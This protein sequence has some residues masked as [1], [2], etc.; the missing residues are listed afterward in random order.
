M[1]GKSKDDI[2]QLPAT[3][4]QRV[5]PAEVK[6]GQPASSDQISTIHRG[7]TVVGKIVGEGTVHLFGQIEGELL[8]STVLINEGAK[9]EG[10]VVAEE[11]TVGGMVKGTIRRGTRLIDL[12]VTNRD[13][14]MAQR[15]CEAVGREYIRN[16]IERRAAFSQES[17]RYLLEEDLKEKLKVRPVVNPQS[18]ASIPILISASHEQL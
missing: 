2:D 7:M 3:E 4:V 13:P 12:F 1:F 9:V 18:E 8:A 6:S 5:S 11:L 10:D 17:L 16:S 15:L 14:V